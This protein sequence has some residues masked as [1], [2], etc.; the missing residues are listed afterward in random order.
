[1]TPALAGGCTC[2]LLDIPSRTQFEQ[3]LSGFEGAV[4]AVVHDR[5]FI[6]SFAEKVWWVEDGS[7][8]VDVLRWNSTGE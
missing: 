6:E 2:L 8:R 1:V 4:L 3:A 7:L 5:Y